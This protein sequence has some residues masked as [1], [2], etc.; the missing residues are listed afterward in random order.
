[1]SMS[2]SPYPPRPVPPPRR[3]VAKT[4]GGAL[5][6]LVSVLFTVGMIGNALTG[7]LAPDDSFTMN[8]GRLIGYLLMICVP[9]WGAVRLLGSH[10][11]E[12]DQW[13]AEQAEQR[14]QR[15]LGGGF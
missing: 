4:A 7:Q 6:A 9:A 8:L 5:L 14:R 13:E 10:T 3:S 2:P 11:R 15:R 1:M 12:L